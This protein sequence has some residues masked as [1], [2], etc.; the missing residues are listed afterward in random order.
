VKRLY[1]LGRVTHQAKTKAI[2]KFIDLLG[3]RTAFWAG[4]RSEAK[5]NS[6]P[7]K[8]ETE[9]RDGQRGK[10]ENAKTETPG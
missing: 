7:N 10:A 3:S 2:L 6:G 5:P 4:L 1:H 9:N 8:T